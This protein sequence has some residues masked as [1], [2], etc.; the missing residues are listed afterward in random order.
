MTDD[1]D[2]EDEEYGVE[3]LLRYWN[4]ELL[5]LPL[6]DE[7]INDLARTWAQAKLL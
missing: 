4:G 7:A 5:L 6:D 3:G 1:E 2:D